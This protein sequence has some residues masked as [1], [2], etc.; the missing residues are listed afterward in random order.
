M[1][2]KNLSPV[3]S[4]AY[5]LHQKGLEFMRE[6]DFRKARLLFVDALEVEPNCSRLLIDYGISLYESEPENN[7][8]PLENAAKI[9]ARVPIE[10]F[11]LTEKYL[12]GHTLELLGRWDQARDAYFSALQSSNGYVDQ[13]ELS[14]IHTGLTQLSEYPD[15][16]MSRPKGFKAPDQ[17]EV[18]FTT[19][20]RKKFY[21]QLRTFLRKG[22]SLRLIT[23]EDRDSVK[24]H[25]SIRPRMIIAVK[26]HLSEP[27]QPTLPENSIWVFHYK[28]F[29]HL[30]HYLERFEKGYNTKYNLV[31]R[32]FSHKEFEALSGYRLL[33][34]REHAL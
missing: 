34:K 22:S 24:E 26:K 9:F 2:F 10:H 7:Y 32:D 11:E 29:E 4:T 1:L 3:N 23:I 31:C 21:F 33:W 19:F 13:I 12:P 28:C 18:L 25:W 6:G 14:M 20:D 30:A 17:N 15:L 27:I 8:N 16:R 5:N